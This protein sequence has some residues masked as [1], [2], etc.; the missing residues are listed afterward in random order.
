[1]VKFNIISLHFIVLLRIDSS[2]LKKENTRDELPESDTSEHF[3]TLSTL[4]K[5][6]LSFLII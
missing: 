3:G 4:G 1:M 5:F 2:D 6:M